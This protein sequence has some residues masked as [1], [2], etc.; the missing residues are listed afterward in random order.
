MST[1]VHRAG[2]LDKGELIPPKKAIFHRALSARPASVER[3]AAERVV[4]GAV[5]GLFP[6]GR[7]LGPGFGS[8]LLERL[9]L[10]LPLLPRL[11]RLF[12]L[13]LRLLRLT[14]GR[15][16]AWNQVARGLAFRPRM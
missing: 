10:I 1:V 6:A 3:E 16:A 4:R 15:L 9:P 11:E 12:K 5:L 13:R 7:L 14:P 8:L 2:L